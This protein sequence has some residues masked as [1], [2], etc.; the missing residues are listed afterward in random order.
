VILTQEEYKLKIN[1]FMYENQFITINNN[2]TQYY[3]KIIKH[4]LI[5]GNIKSMNMNPTAPNLHVR[6]KLKKVNTPIRPIIN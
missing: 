5:Q 3:Q 6:L 1:N 2:P 4:T